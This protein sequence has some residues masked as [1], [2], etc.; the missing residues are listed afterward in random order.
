MKNLYQ[1]RELINLLDYTGFTV[2]LE[3]EEKEE[4]EDVADDNDDGDD[5]DEQQWQQ[6]QQQQEEETTKKS[7]NDVFA[8][9]GEKDKYRKLKENRKSKK[10]WYMTI[11]F[12]FNSCLQ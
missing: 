11:A 8:S 4:E 3:E 12:F 2:L 1:C 6:Q 10:Q 9:A 5:D 7:L